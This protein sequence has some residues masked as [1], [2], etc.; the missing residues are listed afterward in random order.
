MFSQLEVLCLI[1][2]LIIQ[3]VESK[4]YYIFIPNCNGKIKGFCKSCILH[5]TKITKKSH[6]SLCHF[7]DF[8]IFK[9]LPVC[10][11]AKEGTN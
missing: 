5:D 7:Q 2:H 1:N 11:Y 4:M 8:A 6:W 10:Q 9:V 3:I